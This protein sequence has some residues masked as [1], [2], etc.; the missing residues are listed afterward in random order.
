VALDLCG[1]V[2][3]RFGFVTEAAVFD[4]ASFLAG[5]RWTPGVESRARAF[6]QVLIGPTQLTLERTAFTI[7]TGAGAD[8]LL[9]QRVALRFQTDVRM[10]TSAGSR[11]HQIRVLGGFVFN[12]RD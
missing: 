8:F 1:R 4:A 9:S 11:S 3:E 6:V 12:S 2:G 7:Q 10:L 5:A